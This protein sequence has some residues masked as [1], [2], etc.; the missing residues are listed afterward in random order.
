[1]NQLADSFMAIFGYRRVDVPDHIAEA[2]E[3]RAAIL[4]YEA[5]LPKEK[6][7]ALAK[8]EMETWLIGNDRSLNGSE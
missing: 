6:A 2:A 1:M 3:E 7:E 8:A 5:G 4:Q